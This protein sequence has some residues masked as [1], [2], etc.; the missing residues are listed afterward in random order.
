MDLESSCCSRWNKYV[1]PWP[2]CSPT[3]CPRQKTKD[4]TRRSLRESC[5]ANQR[6]IFSQVLRK[7]G[8][9]LTRLPLLFL[10]PVE[11]DGNWRVSDAALGI[12]MAMTLRS[13]T[14]PLG[15]TLS[16]GIGALDPCIHDDIPRPRRDLPCHPQ[17]P[18]A[19]RSKISSLATSTNSCSGS[20]IALVFP[21]L[22]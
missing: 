16:Q 1:S 6:T 2:S 3:H 15:A 7:G 21:D 10:F 5:S 19:I 4:N 14:R 12:A 17:W 18:S 11:R 22:T 9:A 8:K 13:A 20:D